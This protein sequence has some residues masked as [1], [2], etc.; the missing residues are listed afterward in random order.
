MKIPC[1]ENQLC[2]FIEAIKLKRKFLIIFGAIF[3][4]ARSLC[5]YAE[6][7]DVIVVSASK[8]EENQDSASEKVHVISDEDIKKSGAKT[9]SEA[10]GTVPGVVVSSA[11]SKSRSSS[12]MMQGFEGQYVKVLVDG[13][14]LPGDSGGNV[15]LERFP[16]ENIDHIEIVQGASSALFGSDAMGGIVNIITKKQAVSQEKAKISGYIGEEFSTDIRNFVN[17]GIGFAGKHFTSFFSGS[18]DQQKGISEKSFDP[19]IGSVDETQIPKSRLGYAD[20][21]LSWKQDS[22]NIDVY[23]FYSDYKRE[24]TNVGISKNKKYISDSDYFERRAGITLSGKKQ[25]NDY[26][27][28][29]AFASGKR[30]DSGLDEV[31]RLSSTEASSKGATNYELETELRA[32]WTPNLY[33]RAVFGFNG[34][35]EKEDNNYFENEKKQ[36]LLSMFAQNTVDV[37]GGDEKL[38]IVL[39]ERLDF[40][41]EVDGSKHYLQGTPKISLCIKPFDSFTARLSYGMGFK[42]PSLMQKYYVFYHTHGNSGFYIYGNEDLLP[43]VSHGFNLSFDQFFG[44]YLSISESGFFNYHKDM[45]DTEKIT[46]GK[47]YFYRYTNIGEAVTYG[48]IFG[49]NGKFDRFGFKAGYAFTGA[50]QIDDD[51][52]TDLTYRIPHRVTASVSY[53]VPVAETL[54]YVNGEWNSPQLVSAEDDTYSPD[55]LILSAG[56]NKKFWNDRIDLHC[57]AENILNNAHFIEGSDGESQKEFFSMYKGVVFSFGGRVNF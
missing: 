25:F 33:N 51:E 7:D 13:V 34:K 28:L 26:W 1:G 21:K 30:H 45:I 11:N 47:K 4:L 27:E 52:Y 39:G 57:R 8:A 5:I 19:F 37:S 31:K 18:F 48:A 29:S 2:T 41:P 35:F 15:Y 50:K 14:A 40:Q 9:V 16:V 17:A 12:V 36:V 56:I 23:G 32:L 46:E 44:K 53:L 20:G 24:T 49:I 38:M 3:V 54:V 43:E 55:Y 42:V 6:D 22:W 10:L